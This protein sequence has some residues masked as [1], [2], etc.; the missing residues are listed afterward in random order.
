MLPMQLGGLLM[1]ALSIKYLGARIPEPWLL[2]KQHQ[3][4]CS[5]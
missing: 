5:R 1:Q 2:V 4:Q 3:R